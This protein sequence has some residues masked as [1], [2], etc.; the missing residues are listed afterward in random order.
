MSPLTQQEIHEILS[1]NRLPNTS[2]RTTEGVFSLV[3][4]KGGHP[5]AVGAYSADDRPP[6]L[7]LSSADFVKKSGWLPGNRKK[8]PQ[9]DI[10]IS[11]LTKRWSEPPPCARSHFR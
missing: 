2:W 6:I 5:I 10:H 8:I 7:G 9:C 11:H 3:P 4:Q 1:I